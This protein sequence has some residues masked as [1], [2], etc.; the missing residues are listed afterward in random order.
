MPLTQEQLAT[1]AALT[2]AQ[3]TALGD[4]AASM[5]LGAA[6]QR[7]AAAANALPQIKIIPCPNYTVGGDFD[8]WVVHFMDNVRA[9]Y[10][11][12][13]G[14][15]RLADQYKHWLSTKLEPGPARAAYENLPPTTKDDWSLLK[16]ALS[17]AFTDDKEKLD[18]L[19]RLDAHQRTPGMSL[20]HY[21]DTLLQKME[22]YQ[23]WTSTQNG[24]LPQLE[25]TANG[26]L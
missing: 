21:K 15:V 4:L 19:S 22:K 20:R 11:L 13:S 17:D 14:D 8:L 5:G 26:Q 18:F 16:A 23:Q 12:P 2:D 24:E 9:V 1:L 3:R 25:N 7:A 10:N 6:N